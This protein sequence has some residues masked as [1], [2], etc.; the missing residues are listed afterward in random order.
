MCRTAVLKKVGGFWADGIAEDWDMFLRVAEAAELANLDECLYSV[1]VH[2][3]SLNARRMTEMRLRIAYSCDRAERRRRGQPPV[4]YDEFCDRRHTWWRAIA[5]RVDGY[6]MLQ[7]RRAIAEQLGHQAARGRLRLAWAAA[8][9]PHL[10]QQR[11]LRLLR[12]WSRVAEPRHLIPAGAA[13]HEH[14]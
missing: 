14:N 8:C 11:L 13:A 5:D 4:L 3:Q 1:R 12:H 7:Y 10:T 2:S 9:G 6:A